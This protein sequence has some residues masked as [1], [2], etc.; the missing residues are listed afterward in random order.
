MSENS[1]GRDGDSAPPDITMVIDQKVVSTGCVSVLYD[2]FHWL[3]MGWRDFRAEPMA[4]C[5]RHL[6]CLDGRGVEARL[7][8]CAGI[9]RH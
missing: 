5:L 2:T 9:C 8:Q 3:K 1:N 4:G 6:L 7:G